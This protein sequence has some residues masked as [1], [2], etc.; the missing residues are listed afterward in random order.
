MAR[1]RRSQG[2]EFVIQ[3]GHREMNLPEFFRPGE[4]V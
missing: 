1:W 4:E 2:V 3:A